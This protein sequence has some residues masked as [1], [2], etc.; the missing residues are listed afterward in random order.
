MSEQRYLRGSALD[1]RSSS[2]LAELL[3]KVL[4]KGLVV[5]G[6]IRLNVVDVELLTIKLRLLVASVDTAKRMGID[7]WESD[8][9]LSGRNDGAAELTRLQ[10]ENAELQE[11]LDRLERLLPA[12]GDTETSS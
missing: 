7:W 4:D 12:A 2:D 10:Q 3:D 11:R 8:P 5:A 1:R 9:F 6:D